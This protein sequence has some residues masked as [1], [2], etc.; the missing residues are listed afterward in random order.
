MH[1]ETAFYIVGIVYMGLMIIIL[2]ALLIAV[3]VIRAKVTAIHRHVEERLGSAL[4]LFEDG[5]QIVQKVKEAVGNR[6]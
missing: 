4:Q 2:V 1:L 5:S 6:K 3:L